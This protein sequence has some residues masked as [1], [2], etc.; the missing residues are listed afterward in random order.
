MGKKKEIKSYLKIIIIENDN[1]REI[2]GDFEGTL[3]DLGA[4]MFSM[5]EKD[6]RLREVLF[7]VA[8]DLL[9]S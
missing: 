1:K 7:K 8:D 9:N 3:S 5:A 4:M 6:C 2:K